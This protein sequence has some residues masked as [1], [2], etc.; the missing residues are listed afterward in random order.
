MRLEISCEDRQG[1][2]QDVLRLLNDKQIDLRGIEIAQEGKIFLSF[3][4]IDF[5]EFQ[6]VM[7]KLRRIDGINDVKTT[8]FMPIE[9]ERNELRAIIQTMPDPVFSIDIKGRIVLINDAAKNSVDH[10]VSLLLDADINDG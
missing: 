7:A 5:A 9:R 8:L 3:P 4:T 2:T 6:Q 1:I 10:E